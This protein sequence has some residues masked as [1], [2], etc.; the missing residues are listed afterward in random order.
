M[1]PSSAILI[2]DRD[3]LFREALRNFLL[4]AGYPQVEVAATVRH[5]LASIRCRHYRHILISVST[6]G[7][8]ARRLAAIARRRQPQAK[9]LLL[10]SVQDQARVRDVSFDY[11][12]KEDIFSDLLSLM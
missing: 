11:V 1:N 3:A 7:S 2:Y 6:R 8:D 9:I 12:L 10:V 5:A 4:A